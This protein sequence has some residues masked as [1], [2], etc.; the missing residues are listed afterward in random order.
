LFSEATNAAAG[1]DLSE[2]YIIDNK[3]GRLMTESFSRLR[4][5]FLQGGDTSMD[6]RA[7]RHSTLVWLSKL[8][9]QGN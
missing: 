3:P 8:Q 2:F 6:Q 5:A 9:A 4:A 1:E 7:R